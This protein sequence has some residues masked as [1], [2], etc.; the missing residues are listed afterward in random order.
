MPA[1]NDHLPPDLL[2]RLQR[3]YRGHLAETRGLI[4]PMVARAAALTAGGD[5]YA[6]LKHHAH[7]LG[8]S[9]ASYGFGRLSQTG[10]TLDDLLRTDGAADAVGQAATELLA[11]IDEALG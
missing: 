10:K 6:A 9:G 7:K 1:A 3:T 2:D 5:D 8:G 11:A 4:A